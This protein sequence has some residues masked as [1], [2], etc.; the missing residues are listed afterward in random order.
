MLFSP[1]YFLSFLSSLWR[2]TEGCFSFALKNWE[3]IGRFVQEEKKESKMADE[4]DQR[5]VLVEIP[6]P[7]A[8]VTG[9]NIIIIIII[10]KIS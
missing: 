1:F 9:E 8:K 5:S 6:E 4:A 2:D 3:I 7:Q 10:I